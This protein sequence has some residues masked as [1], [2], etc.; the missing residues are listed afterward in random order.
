MLN[1]IPLFCLEAIFSNICY[2]DIHVLDDG[3]DEEQIIE[4]VC[5]LNIT[6]G[7]SEASQTPIDASPSVSYASKGP[8]VQKRS[9]TN[10]NAST[11]P[12]RKTNQKP[13]I[14][15]KE[16][17][18]VNKPNHQSENVL[19]DLELDGIEEPKCNKGQFIDVATFLPELAQPTFDKQ[20]NISKNPVGDI[21]PTSGGKPG[22]PSLPDTSPTIN[23]GAAVVFPRVV[24][25]KKPTVLCMAIPQVREKFNINSISS[26]SLK[27][28]SIKSIIAI[29]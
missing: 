2:F 9:R 24:I 12:Y 11:A 23:D 26:C 17:I 5:N 6:N 7:D 19:L 28:L 18:G 13:D 27:H 4:S 16:R 21:K 25:Y 29:M 10:V 1:G 3:D 22:I 20:S 15:L 14:V 8:M